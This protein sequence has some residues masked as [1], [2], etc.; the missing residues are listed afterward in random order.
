MRNL[1]LILL[2]GSLVTLVLLTSCKPAATPVPAQPSPSPL[3]SPVSPQQIAPEATREILPSPVATP[4]PP[5]AATSGIRIIA[6][7]GPTCPGPQRPG[8]VCAGP[9]E[10]EFSITT[11]N[12]TEAAHVTTDKDG[13]ATVDLPPGQYTVTP[14]IEGR[15]PSG[16]PMDV[17]VLPGQIVEVSIELDTG[18]R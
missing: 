18:I 5:A 6:K 8:Q 14:K 7:V 17:T 9:Y 1:R 13:Q 4:V 12:G 15:L 2:F 11:G 16:T 3:L 10:G